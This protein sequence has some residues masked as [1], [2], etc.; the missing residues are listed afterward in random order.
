MRC[1]PDQYRVQQELHLINQR[2]QP[3]IGR[4]VFVLF[5]FSGPSR[6]WTHIGGEFPGQFGQV[7][8]QHFRGQRVFA[9]SQQRLKAIENLQQQVIGDLRCFMAVVVAA[10]QPSPPANRPASG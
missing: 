3:G 6:L 5:V 9:V 2:F 1:A 4:Q 7:A 8:I 10:C